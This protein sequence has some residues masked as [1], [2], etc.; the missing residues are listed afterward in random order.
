MSQHGSTSVKTYLDRVEPAI[1][2]S[3]T[4]NEETVKIDPAGDAILIVGFSEPT[5]P[6]AH[7]LV[8]SKV[9][10]LAS[11]VF[12]VMFSPK[13]K[14]GSNLNSS[15]P[16]KVTL[17]EDHPEAMTLLCNCLHFRVD[18]IPRDVE[19]SVLKTLAILCDKYDAARAISPW[20]ILWLQ[21]W[22]TTEYEDC[23]E[24]LLA[25]I[26]ALDCAEA[27]TKISRKAILD[28][29]GSF[30]VRRIPDGFDMVPDSLVSMV[31][32]SIVMSISN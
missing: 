8:S 32:Y 14:E 11:P 1:A 17:P 20:S 21:R 23:F 25:I 27:F 16:C 24:G 4:L 19:L 9:L 28:Q 12:A 10:G 13:F 29:V 6:T 22:E 31:K 26:Y 5:A 15:H 3:H 18:H 2:P 7:L 30:D